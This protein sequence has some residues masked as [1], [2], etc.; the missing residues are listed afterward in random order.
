[1]HAEAWSW[2]WPAVMGLVPWLVVG[3][4]CKGFADPS[5]QVWGMGTI[6]TTHYVY[7]K[8]NMCACCIACGIVC[9][10][11]L[12]ERESRHRSQVVIRMRKGPLNQ[13]CT[14]LGPHAG[15][16]LVLL[17]NL[18]PMSLSLRRACTTSSGLDGLT[19]GLPSAFRSKHFIMLDVHYPHH[20]PLLQL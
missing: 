6:L 15:H 18:A 1:M 7:I 12:M 9:L 11:H 3:I 17:V 19:L 14:G 8:G 13:S 2:R 4:Y 16:R 5:M 20:P 10:R